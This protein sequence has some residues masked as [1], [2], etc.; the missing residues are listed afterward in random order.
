VFTSLPRR[1]VRSKYDCRPDLD[2]NT[3]GQT[4]ARHSRGWV[5]GCGG[6]L[7]V[8]AA[9]IHDV[10]HR[11][12]AANSCRWIGLQ[13]LEIIAAHC[14]SPAARAP[15]PPCPQK[16]LHTV[17]GTPQPSLSRQKS[18]TVATGTGS[19]QGFSSAYPPP[20]AGRSCVG[21]PGYPRIVPFGQEAGVV[22]LSETSGIRGKM[23]VFTAPFG[24][25]RRWSLSL[26]F[27]VCW[28]S[29]RHD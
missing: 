6:G 3:P 13:A 7:G 9:P 14:L 16:K 15:I 23:G 22:R 10:V 1:V 25:G 12:S 27:G 4:R 28:C 26:T 21:C 8:P 11:R 24:G 2:V 29:G 17:P 18:Q 5:P 20:P 19:A